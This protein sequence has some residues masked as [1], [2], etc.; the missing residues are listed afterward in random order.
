MSRIVLP[1]GSGFL[2]QAL[3]AR[4]VARGDAVVILSRSDGQQVPAWLARL[5]ATLLGSSASLA[6]TSRRVVPTR[7]LEHGFTFTQPDFEPTV[8]KALHACGLI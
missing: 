7:L 3:A 8:R 4:L 5:G 1:G 6:L 2:G